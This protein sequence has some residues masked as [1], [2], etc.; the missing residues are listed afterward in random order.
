[1]KFESANAMLI[2]GLILG[3]AKNKSVNHM[4]FCGSK[5]N[6]GE[7]ITKKM[8]TKLV[9]PYNLVSRDNLNLAKKPKYNPQFPFGFGG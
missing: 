5:K 1:M 3:Y 8:C 6:L 2:F 9:P 4:T 7:L